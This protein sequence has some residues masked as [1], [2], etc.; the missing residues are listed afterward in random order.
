MV[1]AFVAG[2]DSTFFVHSGIDFMS[3]LRAAW[4]NL[5][6]GGEIK[7]G[8]STIT[9]Q[10]VKGLLLSPERRFRRKIR[11]MILARDIEKRFTKQEILYLYLNQ[12]Y[13]GHGAYGI[14]EATR[15]YF[16]KDVADLTISEGALLA[17]LP[18]APSRYS[19][20]ANPEQA[21]QRRR[22][23]LE[24]ML[25]DGFL[26]DTTYETALAELPVLAESERDGGLRR[27]RL[28]HR[29]GAPLPLRR[30]GRRCRAERRPQ[31]RDDSR[32]GPAAGGGS[33]RAAGPT[34]SQQAPGLPRPPA[35][36]GP[37][38]DSR[39]ARAARAGERPRRGAPEELAR[40]L[41]RS[42]RTSRGRPERPP[43]TLS[44]EGPF[45]GV[46][47]EIDVEG[48]L[49]RVGF[50]PDI[51][52][53][54]H[55]EDVAWAREPDPTKAPRRVRSID[56]VFRVGDVAP[57]LT[58]PGPPGEGE[59]QEALRVT[60]HQEPIVEGAL[61]L[62]R[63]GAPGGPRPGGRLRLPAQPVRPRHPGAAPA[64]LR[65]Q[66]PD[67]W[68][69]AG[70]GL[71]AGLHH[72]RPARRVQ[73]RGVGLHL[74][75]AQLRSLVLRADH[76]ARGPGALGQQRHRP[77]LPGRGRRLRDRL[78]AAPGD[79]IPAQPRP[80]AC[81]GLERPLA[82]R[83]DARLRDL[84]Q[85]GPPR[86]ADLRAARY[87]PGGR[88]SARARTPG[89]RPTRAG[90]ASRRRTRRSSPTSRPRPSARTAAKSSTAPTR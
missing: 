58:L 78:R 53:V 59:A 36:R 68:R 43:R 39:R 20:R 54:V 18:K 85:P 12:I 80:L 26:D 21:E 3:I 44:G 47:T 70:Q 45:V 76:A 27:G 67:L 52:A 50:A 55:L 4:V 32:P 25:A 31:H 7:Q 10:M 77:P 75:P 6:A 49:A 82:A 23:V 46:V 51:E 34:G 64:R 62:A 28:L 13:F 19:P 16:G 83:A 24:R 57:F 1:R 33:R 9:Q 8:G 88:G 56:L 11:E 5:R 40:A 81:A 61:A 42:C 63:R 30:A 66:A 72:L 2:E 14:G 17:G 69:R 29:G 48:K 84:P 65:L 35:P 41:P 86:R 73:G 22:Y 89:P 87:E 90:P 37:R 79:R 15:T 60:L 38:G 71:H 74:A